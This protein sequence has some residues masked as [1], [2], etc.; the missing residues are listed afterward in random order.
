MPRPKPP[1]F[2]T[3]ELRTGALD[4]LRDIIDTAQQLAGDAE[5]K[6]EFGGR[7]INDRNFAARVA[8]CA[9]QQT[10]AIKRLRSFL[11]FA[12]EA[13]LAELAWASVERLLSASRTCTKR[14]IELV[15]HLLN[16]RPEDVRTTTSVARSGGTASHH[17]APRGSL[18]VDWHET[19]DDHRQVIL[20][21]LPEADLFPAVFVFSADRNQWYPQH[22][23]VR[24][25][26]RGGLAFVCNARFGNPHGIGHVPKP[27]KKPFPWY[28]KVRVYA[29]GEEP[30]KERIPAVLSDD[31][32][33]RWASE[34][35]VASQTETPVK[36]DWPPI[37]SIV[38]EGHR[39]RDEWTFHPP[40]C[41]TCT[42]PLN[43]SWRTRTTVYY[44]IRKAP[45]DEVVH[46][47]DV[48]DDCQMRIVDKASSLPM[49]PGVERVPL[50]GP[51]IYRLRYWGMRKSF[52]D[53]ELE[54]WMAIKPEPTTAARK[55]L[56]EGVARRPSVSLRR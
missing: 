31:Q 16:M 4:V 32:L 8:S 51:G 15:A 35:R 40:E 36:R 22:D 3:E 12:T 20:G 13:K 42:F 17:Q 1:T 23:L 56:R 49:P 18:L 29:L 43:L 28:G 11:A 27:D 2:L 54:L 48:R 30:Q 25:K 38:V 21:Q 7:T 44:E 6:R 41:V 52:L 26:K 5:D 50:P 53:Q 34:H 24:M 10:P 14:T 9:D 39:E 33:D 37:A 47:G 46:E 55:P 19:I 45:T